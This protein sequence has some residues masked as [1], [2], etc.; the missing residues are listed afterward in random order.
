MNNK[1]YNKLLEK[2]LKRALKG[3]D[4]DS[5][6]QEVSKLLSS[7]SAS[8]DHFERDRKLLERAMHLSSEE[9][10][11]SYEQKLV[12]IELEQSN[13][14]LQ[15]FV[16]IASH[17]LK[18]PLR[19]VSSFT[20]LLNRQLKGSLNEESSE[21]MDFI[22]SGV[23]NMQNLLDDLT[24]FAKI[25]LEREEAEMVDFNTILEMVQRNL[26]FSIEESNAS[27]ILEDPLP[28]FKTHPYQVIQIFQNIIGN[29]I[30]FRQEGVA[31]KIIIRCKEVANATQI[32]ISDNGMGIEQKQHSKAFE[33][34]ARL[35]SSQHKVAGSG[36]GLSICKKIVDIWQGRIWFESE[37]N[38]GTTF[39]FTLPCAK[40]T[41]QKTDISISQKQSS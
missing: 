2:Q 29:A 23:K 26:S 27:I 39:F 30:K 13:E 34:F 19:T 4:K 11:K 17:D 12:Q 20:Q 16:S 40:E 10:R 3:K 41:Q 36:L 35:S 14:Y 37:L 25:G 28:L 5:L 6:P 31:P 7:V 9:I 1:P 8:Y 32:S 22:L 21:Y 38:K 24:S 18:A 15:Q 33:A